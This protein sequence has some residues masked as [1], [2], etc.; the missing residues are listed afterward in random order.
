V[1]RELA[2]GKTKC[3]SFGPRLLRDWEGARRSGVR[4][5][6]LYSIQRRKLNVEA[7]LED[8]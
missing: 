2:I 7:G 1:R 5:F 3:Q 6:N 8:F 4:T